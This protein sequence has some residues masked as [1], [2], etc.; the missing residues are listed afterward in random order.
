MSDDPSRSLARAE[1]TEGLECDDPSRSLARAERTGGRLVLLR[2]GETDGNVAGRLD[3]RP[4]GSPLT[5][6]GHRQARDF[7]L[8]QPVPPGLLLHSV[9]LRAGQTA[10]E[11][12][13][14]T[15]VGCNE[16]D[17]VYEVQAGDLEDRAD[18]AAHD[19]FTRIYRGWHS[20]ALQ[21]R[22]PGGESGRDVLD[23]YLP[24]VS[25]LRRDYLEN[26]DFTAD[27]LVV[28]H[29]AAIRLVA[30]ALAG[31]DGEFAMRNQLANTES[32]VLEPTDGGGWRCVQWAGLTLSPAEPA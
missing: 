32:V 27:L 20:G 6:A 4:P 29:G 15:A 11:I 22:M 26:P 9:A 28:S 25:D 7:A 14:I 17:G 18:E 23:R 24:V 19:E 3:T 13:D 8:A 21:L 16:V 31:I 5:P 30:A 1:R 10:A 2:H 12:S